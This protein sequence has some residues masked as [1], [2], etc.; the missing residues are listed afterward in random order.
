MPGLIWNMMMSMSGGWFFVVA[1]EAISVGNLQIALPGVG[2]YVAMAIQQ[3]NLAA[4]GW[5]ILAMTI[6]ILLY[7]QLAVPADGRL[8]RQVPRRA[9]GGAN[10]AEKL[11][12]RSVSP[13]AYRR[14][15]APVGMGPDCMGGA[16][17]AG[18]AARRSS[19]RLAARLGRVADVLWLAASSRPSP[20][21]RGGSRDY[22]ARPLI[23]GTISGSSLPTGAL[24]SLRVV[25]PHC[26][27]LSIWV[28]I[29]VAVGLRPRLDGRQ[30][31]PVAQ[32]LA[33]F[34]ANL[35]FPVVV[36]FIVRFQ[37]RAQDLARSADDSGHP[38]VHPVQ[39]HCRRECVSERFAG[40]GRELSRRRL[41]LV[42]RRH[43]AR[44]SFLTM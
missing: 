9:N 43:A 44:A 25:V 42:A 38:V 41:A 2:S 30:V 5:A 32:F 13:L 21:L 16:R 37:S 18:A 24:R 19:D 36:S 14:S 3:R 33:A 22:A 31:Q 10:R 12:S 35:L 17:A 15:A 28:P 26:A 8:G 39:R 11:G 7:D 1:S 40:S 34:P 29:G 6:A 4:V 23:V 20:M 27:R